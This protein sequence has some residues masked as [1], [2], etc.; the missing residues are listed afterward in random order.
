MEEKQHLIQMLKEQTYKHDRIFN[1][2]HDGMIFID[3]N[4]EIILFNHMAEKMV[5][6]NARKSSGARSKKSFRAQRCRG[7]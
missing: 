4:E 3:I 5:G 6:K 1:S 7:F 2:T